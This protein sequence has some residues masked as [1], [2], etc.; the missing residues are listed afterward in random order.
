MAPQN[1]HKSVSKTRPQALK[2]SI[3]W[4]TLPPTGRLKHAK[5]PPMC[6][7]PPHV[8]TH[9]SPKASN[10]TPTAPRTKFGTLVESNWRAFEH[11]SRWRHIDSTRNA[12]KSQR[13]S[14]THWNTTRRHNVPSVALQWEPPI[15]IVKTDV[16]THSRK[17]RTRAIDHCMSDGHSCKSN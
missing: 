4:T 12:Y 13:H 2:G 16:F 14:R 3:S 8:W 9:Q 10:R 6:H 5:R 1:T 15:N 11:P 17:T 7:C